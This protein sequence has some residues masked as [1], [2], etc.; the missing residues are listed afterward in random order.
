M[1]RQMPQIWPRELPVLLSL[2][3]GPTRTTTIVL[4]N[5]LKYRLRLGN[6]FL[7]LHSLLELADLNRFIEARRNSKTA[8]DRVTKK[9]SSDFKH[10]GSVKFFLRSTAELQA[11]GFKGVSPYDVASTPKSMI[12]SK[13]ATILS[14]VKNSFIGVSSRTLK[15]GNKGFDDED[16]EESLVV[17]S[18]GLS[19][20]SPENAS[21][22]NSSDPQGFTFSG[23]CQDQALLSVRNGTPDPGSTLPNETS[24]HAL[25]KDTYIKLESDQNQSL[26]EECRNIDKATTSIS[27]LKGGPAFNAWDDRDKIAQERSREQELEMTMILDGRQSPHAPI[28]MEGADFENPVRHS[29]IEQGSPV[30]PIP[31]F[32]PINQPSLDIQG[33]NLP[34]GKNK[35]VQ[36][37]QITIRTTEEEATETSRV[38]KGLSRVTVD[39]SQV[40]FPPIEC[41]PSIPTMSSDTIFPNSSSCSSSNLSHV[42]IAIDKFDN[43]QSANTSPKLSRAPFAIEQDVQESQQ[44]LQTPNG[45]IKHMNQSLDLGSQEGLSK[46]ALSPFLPS[47]EC[48][49]VPQIP[50]KDNKRKMDYLNKSPSMLR[51][52]K[53]SRKALISPAQR[54]PTELMSNRQAVM[55]RLSVAR[56]KNKALMQQCKVRLEVQVSKA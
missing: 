34:V 22:G 11:L 54:I 48:S 31:A 55:T 17:P 50:R 39:N 42:L 30:F 15:A 16:E 10:V 14:K 36:D 3:H 29:S 23:Y 44:M 26:T 6:S 38:R 27:G 45:S 46:D 52:E 24:F 2:V 51:K 49:S 20:R 19:S 18:L 40:S 21:N 28:S 1:I 5:T 33:R 8:V 25:Q 53:M 32:T 13:P 47:S 4:V 35:E 56:Q 43:Q 12:R 37:S 9:W 7:E 41:F